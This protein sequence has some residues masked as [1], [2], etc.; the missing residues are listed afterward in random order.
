M[1]KELHTPE[2][3][4]KILDNQ[5]DYTRKH[6]HSLYEKVDVKTKKTILD[7]GCGTGVITA[8]IASLTDGRITGID[9][10]DKKLAYAKPLISDRITIMQADVLELPFKD[11]TFDLVVFSVVLVHIHQ[12]QKAV[13]EMVRVAKKGGIVLATLEPDY[14]GGFHYPE[15]EADPIF[16]KNLEEIGVEMETGRKLRYLFVKAGLQ[17]EIG[18]YSDVVN[19]FNE[20]SEKKVERY[21]EYFYKTEEL[22]LKNGWTKKQVEEY[23]Q[24]QLA[25][26]KNNLTFSFTPAFYAIGRK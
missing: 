22:L 21:L 14:A 13:N 24:K 12:Q 7:I 18:V 2:E 1:S 8:D 4:K 26:I 9:I 25:L 11:N 19:F 10:D 15:T 5:A 6:R 16:E 23:K 3:W 20:D 17:T